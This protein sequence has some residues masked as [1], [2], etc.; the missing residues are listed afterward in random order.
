MS[1]WFKEMKHN[2]TEFTNDW[3]SLVE[4]GCEYRE[5]LIRKAQADPENADAIVSDDYIMSMC[6]KN[7]G[8]FANDQPGALPTA[9]DYF[10]HLTLGML[11]VTCINDRL[12]NTIPRV[13]LNN[14]VIKMLE[15][16]VT[17]SIPLH[18]QWAM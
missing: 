11:E 4:K 18:Q 15:K 12:Q 3:P 14:L 10:F 13:I 6:I 1:M 7:Y 8:V 9:D 17:M 5:D 2:P 16:E